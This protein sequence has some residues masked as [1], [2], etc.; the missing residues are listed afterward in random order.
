MIPWSRSDSLTLDTLVDTLCLSVIG[1]NARYNMCGDDSVEK[2]KVGNN[3][4]NNNY[5]DYDDEFTLDDGTYATYEENDANR[6][7]RK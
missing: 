6:G 7:R 1:R 3:N 2:S 5:D 4:N